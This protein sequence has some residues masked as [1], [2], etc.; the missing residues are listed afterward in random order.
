MLIS[1]NWLKEIGIDPDKYVRH[2]AGLSPYKYSYET[3]CRKLS[4]NR[5]VIIPILLKHLPGMVVKKENELGEYVY[6]MS[7]FFDVMNKFR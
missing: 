7:R 4:D 1:W 3:M 2:T 5:K 6:D